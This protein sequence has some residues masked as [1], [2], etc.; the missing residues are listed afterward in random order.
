MQ[1]ANI[2]D[3]KTKIQI[4]SIMLALVLTCYVP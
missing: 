3:P 4:I 1:E 2:D